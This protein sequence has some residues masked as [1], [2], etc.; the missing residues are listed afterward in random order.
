MPDEPSETRFRVLRVAAGVLR[1]GDH[2][3]V[4]AVQPGRAGDVRQRH[5][6]RLLGWFPPHGRGQQGARRLAPPPGPAAHR[7]RRPV[8]F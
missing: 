8:Q 5:G 3:D 1:N 2:R 7:M 6:L 4:G